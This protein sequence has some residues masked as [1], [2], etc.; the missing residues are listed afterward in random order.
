MAKTGVL[1]CLQDLVA[2]IYI[3]VLDWKTKMSWLIQV[4]TPSEEDL[5]N[6]AHHTDAAA[7]PD[8]I[9]QAAAG[10]QVTCQLS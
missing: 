3:G 2:S 8:A 7:I 9:L 4:G 1:L 10:T 6:W 5:S